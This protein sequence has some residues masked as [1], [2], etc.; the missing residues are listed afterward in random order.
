VTDRRFPS[1]IAAAFE[2]RE[3][4]SRATAAGRAALGARPSIRAGLRKAG[5][6]AWRRA[7][8]RTTGSPIPSVSARASR[9]P[10]GWP[11]C[12]VRTAGRRARPGRLRCQRPGYR[13]D[14][15]RRSRATPGARQEPEPIRRTSAFARP[16]RRA[17]AGES[18]LSVQIVEQAL[19]KVGALADRLDHPQL[20]V[21]AEVLRR[22]VKR[23]G[24][25][26]QQI[27]ARRT[28][29]VRA[30]NQSRQV[31]LRDLRRP[32]QTQ[33]RPAALIQKAPDRRTERLFGAVGRGHTRRLT[34]AAVAVDL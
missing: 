10:A 21:L 24:D 33:Q 12:E 6:R 13:T 31:T 5:A 3:L 20:A 2:R 16:A 14:R 26:T 8:Q 17:R 28:P 27:K 7:D 15:T 32:G 34:S 29:V 22:K 19:A 18:G 4:C 25:P 9:A 11:D 1:N 23:R 30:S